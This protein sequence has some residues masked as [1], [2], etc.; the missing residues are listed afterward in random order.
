LQVNLQWDD[1]TKTTLNSLLSNFSFASIKTTLQ[2]AMTSFT[3]TEQRRVKYW[4]Q[5]NVPPPKEVEK[6]LGNLTSSETS[7]LSGD[8]KIGDNNA[9]Y[10]F[11]VPKVN[12]PGAFTE[13]EKSNIQLYFGKLMNVCKNTVNGMSR[14]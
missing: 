14:K 11:L 4:C 6:L 10:A 8:I 1:S 7:T 2:H 13:K 12:A 3:I 9:I 5:E